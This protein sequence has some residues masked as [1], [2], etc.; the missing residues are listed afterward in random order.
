MDEFTY[1]VRFPADLR[2]DRIVIN[3]TT[4][5]YLEEGTVMVFLK[6]WNGII[7]PVSNLVEEWVH[8]RGIPPKWFDWVTLRQVAST[9]GKLV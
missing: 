3:K 5:F 9:I 2:V 6:E 8:V 4:Y 1:L 7:E